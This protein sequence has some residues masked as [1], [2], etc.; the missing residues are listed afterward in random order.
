MPLLIPHLLPHSADDQPPASKRAK[1]ASS[2][3][4]ASK[5]K[6]KQK[7]P[8][9]ESDLGVDISS[10]IYGNQV[11]PVYEKQRL[12]DRV[13]SSWKAIESLENKYEQQ[14]KTSP[15]SGLC[16]LF[17]PYSTLRNP[18]TLVK[19]EKY[20]AGAQPFRVKVHTNAVCALLVAILFASCCAHLYL[21]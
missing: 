8:F 1:R 16:L 9:R 13:T 20:D 21:I 4:S 14:L 7:K 19:A 6:S 11:A 2:S 10:I 17:F 3:D 15:F 18:L 12:R 5:Q